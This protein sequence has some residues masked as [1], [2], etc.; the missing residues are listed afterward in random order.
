MNDLFVDPPLTNFGTV[1]AFYE[2]SVVEGLEDVAASE[3][4]SLGKG[5]RLRFAPDRYPGAIQFDYAG[6]ARR[7]LTLQTLVAVFLVKRFEV[8]RPLALLGHQNFHLLLR[9]IESIR[10]LHPQDAFRR[11][12]L[13]AAGSGSRVMNRLKEELSRSTGLKISQEEGDLLLRLRRPLDGSDAWEA[14]LRISPRP[15]STRSWRVCDF[16]GALNATVA[17]AMVRMQQPRKEDVYLNLACGSGSLLIERL[18]CA[19]AAQA[20]GCDIDPK[21]LECARQN[22]FAGGYARRAALYPWDARALPLASGSVNALSADLP[23]GHLVGSHDENVVLY[24][25]ILDEA[26]RVARPGARFALISHEVRLLERLLAG[27][28]AWITQK[29]VTITLRGLH[30][31]IFLLERM[32]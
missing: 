25:K 4:R 29:V 13:A 1:T 8:P 16:E 32:P 14:L 31:R 11:L 18:A 12:Y 30:P 5:L 7:L 2:A 15:L 17:N 6:D 9:H 10:N 23:F 3:L 27:S 21:A 28:T 26:A 19:P 22:L 24:P 20:M